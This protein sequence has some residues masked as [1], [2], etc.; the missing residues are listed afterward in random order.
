MGFTVPNFNLSV[1]IWRNASGPP[2]T[3]D[4]VVMGNLAYGRRTNS[5]QGLYVAD[6]EPVLQLL[7]P[8]GTDIRGPQCASLAD[9]VEV[10]AGT[11]RIYLVFG[12]DDS[13][14]GWPN[15]HRVASISWST[16]FG[17]WP[18]PIP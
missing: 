8:P 9:W 17:A 14:K 13:G 12:V 16:N 4:V 18:A 1:N 5:V 2:A 6:H 11:G 3:P 7:L 10:P 15:E